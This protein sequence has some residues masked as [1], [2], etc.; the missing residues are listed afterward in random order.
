[1]KNLFLAAITVAAMTVSGCGSDDVKCSDKGNCAQDSTPSATYVTGCQ[2]MLAS[3][4]G[5]QFQAVLN[6]VKA[7]EKCDSSGKMDLPA[8]ESACS[9]QFGS[10]AACCLA[11]PTAA[12]CTSSVAH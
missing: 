2:A 8:T 9:T 12:G 5:S 3:T 1:M 6:C 7:N 4:C 11:N 10:Y